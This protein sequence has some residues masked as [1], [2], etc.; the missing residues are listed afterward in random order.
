MQDDPSA[1]P[2]LE[3]LR[4]AFAAE[5]ACLLANLRSS[6]RIRHPG[7]RGQVNEQF[8][9]DFLRAYLPNRY[10]VEKAAILDGTGATSRSIDVVVFDRQYTPTLLDNAKHRY[11]PAEAVYAVFECKPRINKQHLEYA[12]AMAASVRSLRRSSIPIQ[13]AGGIFP[14]KKPFAIVGGIFSLDVEWSD[15]LG[16]SFMQ[17]HRALQGDERIDCGFAAAGASFDTF[18]EDSYSFGAGQDA[19]AL[20]VFRLLWKLQSLATVPAVDWRAYAASFTQENES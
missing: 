14:P 1:N 16:E 11:V 7:D 9:I 3:F 15:G 2:N 20:F 19:L 4:S 17:T 5:Q 10:T 18:D 6:K 12:A 13:H 8:F